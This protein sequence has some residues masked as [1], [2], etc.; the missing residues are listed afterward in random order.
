MNKK[1]L[2]LVCAGILA[3]SVVGCSPKND[4]DTKNEEPKTEAST[5]KEE[6]TESDLKDGTYEA[7]TKEA[8]DKGY[9]ATATVV[10]KDGKISEA[11]YVEFSDEK[12]D[13]KD[14]KEYNDK[15]KEVAGTNPQE[16]EVSIAD[17]VVEVQSGDIDGVSG[18]TGSTAKAKQLF[19]K[20][21]ENAKA[22]KTDKELI[23]VKAAE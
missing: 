16:Y 20:A 14:D 13:K 6:K 21:I 11:K 23:E 4:E 1:L 2:S 9:K 22:G 12:G 10:V 17:Q 8:D 15:M 3:I 7:E 5:Q 18:A 19:N